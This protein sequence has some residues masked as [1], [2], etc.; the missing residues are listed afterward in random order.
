MRSY[1]SK[2]HWYR[3]RASGQCRDFQCVTF[4]FNTTKH[5]CSFFATL[6]AGKAAIFIHFATNP[7]CFQSPKPA[8]C[9]EIQ[10]HCARTEEAT[11]QSIQNPTSG[12]DGQLT[13]GGPCQVV[14]DELAD[15]HQ[16]QRVH[17]MRDVEVPV[18][19]GADQASTRQRVTTACHARYRNSYATQTKY[20]QLYSQH[21]H[22]HKAY[23]N[24]ATAINKLHFIREMCSRI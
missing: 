15:L 11:V 21:A 10:D 23:C 18:Y 1:H 13:D 2:A 17:V 24:A 19:D 9:Q 8:R 14:V 3:R 22:Q 4:V 5:D 6:D 7:S 20:I 16:H 12:V